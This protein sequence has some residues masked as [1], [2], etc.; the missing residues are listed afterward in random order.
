MR[1]ILDGG[2]SRGSVINEHLDVVNDQMH[3]PNECMW[4]FKNIKR[5]FQ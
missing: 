4:L 5:T 1:H 3:L 2:H